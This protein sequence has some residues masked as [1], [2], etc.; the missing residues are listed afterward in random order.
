MSV[1]LDLRI[2]GSCVH[3]E[4][5]ILRTRSFRN[6][7]FPAMFA[8]VEHDNEGLTLFDTGYGEA[9][10]RCTAR[11][12]ERLYRAITPVTFDR[13]SSARAI[14]ERRGAKASDVRR[15]VI[16]HFHGDHIGA[17]DEFPKAELVFAPGALDGLTG[18]SRTRALMHGFLPGLLPRDFSDR[19]RPLRGEE[20]PLPP[21][22]AP[23][24]RGIDLFGDRSV[25][26]VPLPGHA[27]GQLGL[28]VEADTPFFLCADAAWLSRSYR[29][30]VVPHPIT[31]LLVDDHAAYVDTLAKLHAL[32]RRNA[33]HIV[34]S[35]C[36]EALR[37]HSAR[38]S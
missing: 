6:L 34:P 26:A 25:M 11:F 13:S 27:R 35:H 32:G 17:L 18:L 4:H 38:A 2:A 5:V 22:C 12:P 30:N 37:R 28:F 3:P 10:F 16:S 20:V 19:A 33:L 14:L 29:E 21:S 7:T 23:F 8:I 1:R 24:E 15:I 31:R 9:F 36:E